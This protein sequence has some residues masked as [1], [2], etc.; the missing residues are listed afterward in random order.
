MQ[1]NW[2]AVANGNPTV[3][4]WDTHADNFGPLK[5]LHC[6]KLD[7]GLPAL[8]EDLDER[9]LLKDT[10]VL[11]IGEFGRSPQDGR[12]HQR[13]QQQRPTAATT[14]R[15]ATPRLMA[16]GGIARGARLRQERQDRLVA[17]RKTRSTRSSCSRRSTTRWAST[18]TRW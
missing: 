5:N 13:Q 7:S 6:P 10:I 3:D 15:T 11:A 14:G 4:A 18:R 2:P 8:I 1:V 16:G 9:G 17:R 12:Q